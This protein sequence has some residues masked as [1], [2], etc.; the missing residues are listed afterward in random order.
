M[1]LVGKTGMELKRLRVTARQ[2]ERSREPIG[3]RLLGP[4]EEAATEAGLT[5]RR[6]P[7]RSRLWDEMRTALIIGHLR[8]EVKHIT[9][10][11]MAQDG[12]ER[13]YAQAQFSSGVGMRYDAHIVHV[14]VKGEPRRIF[15]IPAYVLNRIPV[16]CGRRYAWIP[17]NA[18]TIRRRSRVDW[19][20]YE[21]AWHLLE[22]E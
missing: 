1:P 10:L 11:K 19:T 21:N 2:E 7:R 14:D 17:M 20:K 15:V 5:V 6:F 18:A 9:R 12:R 16:R 8:C 22:G 4:V 3:G 13:R